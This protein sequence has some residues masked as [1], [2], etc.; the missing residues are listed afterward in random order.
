L[1][2]PVIRA[3]ASVAPRIPRPARAAHSEPAPSI[4]PQQAWEQQQVDYERARAAYDAGER[5]AGY[6][7]AQQNNIRLQRY[8]RVAAERTP[9]FVEGCMNYLRPG[10]S[11][12]APQEPVAE[13][14]PEQG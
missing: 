10:R 12:S 14:P 9:A 5:T 2:A 8:C 3:K 13:H 11:D 6:R 7:W 4:T 1:P